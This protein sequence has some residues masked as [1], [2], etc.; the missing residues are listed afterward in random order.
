MKVTEDSTRA[1]G[2]T[3]NGKIVWIQGIVTNQ[4]AYSSCRRWPQHGRGIEL[5]SSD[6]K[7]GAKSAWIY[8]GLVDWVIMEMVVVMVEVW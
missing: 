6:Y 1:G 5:L 3:V 8:L 2:P 4:R 7:A